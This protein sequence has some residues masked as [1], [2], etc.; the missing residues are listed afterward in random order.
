M[1]KQFNNLKEIG[2]VCGLIAWAILTSS[3]TTKINTL[4]SNYLN[5][6]ETTFKRLSK[7]KPH[8]ALLKK[9]VSS[10]N[11]KV[12]IQNNT[13]IIVTTEIMKTIDQ[14]KNNL[15]DL[16]IPFEKIEINTKENTI[17]CVLN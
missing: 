8:I 2:L 16:S 10:I 11:T 12:S 13:L 9:R 3:T 4:R 5:N 7:N 17:I 15:I 1:T 14:L 6:I